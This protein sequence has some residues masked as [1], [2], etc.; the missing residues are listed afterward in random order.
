MPLITI[1]TI[2]IQVYFAVHSVKTGKD[3]Y[4]IFIIIFFPG[5]GCLVYFF[6]EY[7]PELQQNA[8]IR[9]AQTPSNPAKMLQALKDQLELTPSINNKKALAEAYVHTGQFEDAISLY[10]SCL[11]GQYK[12]DPGIIEGLSITYFFKS[13]FENAKKSLER[14]K[15]LRQQ[16]RSDK[17]DLLYARTLENMN[18]TEQALK[19]YE[20]LISG[21][22][23]EE[24][25]VRYGMLLKKS[26]RTEEANEQFKIVLKGARLSEKFYRKAQKEWIDI[27]RKAY[28]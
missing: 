21:F 4:W 26:G 17:F 8:K 20:S 13:D 28:T 18:H 24:A 19:E 5:I 11:T 12:D 27:A 10:E 3:R 1:I 16:N 23:G 9:R 7:L 6:A 14:L 2:A 22:S 15:E 25:R